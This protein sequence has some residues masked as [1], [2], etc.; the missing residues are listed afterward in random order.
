M[1]SAGQRWWFQSFCSFHQKKE[2]EALTKPLLFHPKNVMILPTT[3]HSLW[4]SLGDQEMTRWIQQSALDAM[5][6]KARRIDE[7]APELSSAVYRQVLLMQIDNYWRRHLKFMTNL[8]NYS[9]L[10]TGFSG[11]FLPCCF[12][13]GSIIFGEF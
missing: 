13:D 4:G 11:F 8:R 3:R 1:R 12:F 10:R 7:D 5:K 2:E 6:R 9:K